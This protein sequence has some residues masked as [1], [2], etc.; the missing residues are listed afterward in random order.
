MPIDRIYRKH[1]DHLG[2]IKSLLQRDA[3]FR[4]LCADYQEM[5][6]WC[7][8]HCQSDSLQKDE[9][10]AARKVLADLEREIETALQGCPTDMERRQ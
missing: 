9:C 3:A 1:S 10:H 4:E 8:A 7:E 2:C 5:C 6:A